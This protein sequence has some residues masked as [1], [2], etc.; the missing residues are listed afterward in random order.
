M[1]HSLGLVAAR[2][3]VSACAATAAFAVVAIG[4]S[5]WASD[6]AGHATAKASKTE[7]LVENA[8]LELAS[9]EGASLVEH[10]R[11][12][13]TYNAPVTT[14]LTIHTGHVTA[15]VTV[16]PRGGSI[17]GTAVANYIV[18]N[19][20]GYFGGTF[21]ITHGTGTYRHAFGKDLGISGTIDRDTFALTVK[22][23]GWLNP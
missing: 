4:P 18:K 11:A 23:H 15:V 5:A 12:T 10:G 9:E 2:L 21:T 19:S 13:G 7:Y 16:F 17:T 22:A 8:Q 20:T 14:I 6:M 1:R 3:T